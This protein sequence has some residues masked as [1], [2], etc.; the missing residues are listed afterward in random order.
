MMNGPVIVQFDDKKQRMSILKQDDRSVLVSAPMVFDP[1]P[2]DSVTLA[3]VPVPAITMLNMSVHI[4]KVSNDPKRAAGTKVGDTDK[5]R[6]VYDANAVDART[7]R[8]PLLNFQHFIG[9]SYMPAS[10]DAKMMPV[11]DAWLDL[12]TKPYKV[13]FKA[14]VVHGLPIIIDADENA[15]RLTIRSQGADSEVYLTGPYDIDPTPITGAEAI[16]AGTAAPAGSRPAGPSLN[17]QSPAATP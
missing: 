5:V 15:R 6:L 9:G 17:S 3:V 2:V 11:D 16:A 14:A 4:D 8:V 13:H 1:K 10:P 12:S 7:Q